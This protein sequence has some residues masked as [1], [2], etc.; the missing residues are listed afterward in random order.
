MRGRESSRASNRESNGAWSGSPQP[1]AGAQGKKAVPH[2]Q[3]LA[4]GSA[5]EVGEE[6]EE[7]RE[8]DAEDEAGDDGEVKRSMLAAMDDVAGKF[9]EPER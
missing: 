3:G 4:A 6:P 5:A 8:G 9:A 7:E 2:N 1:F